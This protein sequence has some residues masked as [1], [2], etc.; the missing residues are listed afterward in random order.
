M[1]SFVT[2]VFVGRKQE[3]SQLEHAL[4]A[5]QDGSGRCVLVSGEAGIGKSRLLAEIRDRAVDR[6]FTALVGRC[7]E[8]DTTF[9]Y[10][11]LVDLLRTCFA[12]RELSDILDTLG[13]Q[14]PAV[15]KLL[16]ELAAHVSAQQPEPTPEPE[17]EKRR[18]FE[19]LA[20]FF[21]RQTEAQ[22]LLLTIEDAHWSDAASLEFL[23]FLARRSAPYPL[24]LL[25]SYR[26]AEGQ[27]GL[28]PL[29]TGLDREPIAQALTLEPLT[30]REVARMLQAI[31]DQ[32]QVPSAE[33]VAAVYHL[34]EGNPFLAEEILTSLIARGDIYLAEGR[35]QRKPLAQ[36]D[37]PDS[38]QRLV[39][40]RL[41]RVSQPARRLLDL[42]A[43][44]G[45][46]F[47]F[48]VLQALTG[49]NEKELLAL[50]KELMAAQLV[51][52]ESAEQ[53]AFRHALTREALYTQLLARERQTLH[54][55]MAQT[56]EQI[57]AGALEAH[58]EALAYHF[59]EATL[60]PKALEYA[61]R[62]GA[63]AQALF[64]PHAAIEQF[65]RA[66][67]AL[68]R[69]AQPPP[70]DLYRQRGQAS[71]TLGQFEQARV[72]Y[73]AALEAA[74]AAGDQRATWQALLD[75]GLLWASRDYERTGDYCRQA[76]E[77]TRSME[78][79]AAIGHS[80][81]RLGN[82]LMNSGRPFEALDYHREA[83]DLF[84][85]LDDRPGL[86]A[87][88]DL[89][90]M[91]SNQCGDWA[92]MVTYWERAIPILRDLNDR[93]TL[94]STLAN[95]VMYTLNLEQAHE[96]M[97]LARDIGW[98]AGEAY[99]LGTL[100][101]ALFML[102]HYDR[103]LTTRKQSFEVAQAIEHP[104]W[105]TSGHVFLGRMYTELLALDEAAAHLREGLALARQIGSS[106]FSWVAAGSL[107]S[108]YIWQGNLDA[109]EKLL[110]DAPETWQP[111]L[112]AIRLAQIELALA[113]QDGVGM[114]QLL[115]DIL[116]IE[117]P[118]ETARGAV[119]LLQAPA[120]TL[121]G[122]ALALQGRRAEAEPVL[123]Q[124]V[125]LYETYGIGHHRLWQLYLALGQVYQAASQAER[126]AE[127]FNAARVHIETLASAIGDEALAENFR[128]AGHFSFDN[129]FRHFGAPFVNKMV[130]LI[131]R[132]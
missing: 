119:L 81:N 47:D 37:I 120:L 10:A 124:V 14:A 116:N 32:P 92:A 131:D 59:F 102:G 50:I 122:R 29:L 6:G 126:A 114:L 61:Q 16:P 15:A 84:E 121:H 78:D 93:Q 127:A 19:A 18:L 73:E 13:K 34:T 89:L 88:L 77:L 125:N 91:T 109:A 28:T 118:P 49:H 17:A 68:R 4:A 72:D 43:V 7:F 123:R 80:L 106:W 128:R 79:P 82:W 101:E 132:T 70:P 107:A 67:E 35:W 54:G 1:G 97:A 3:L 75:L 111:V 42:A 108:V 11:P 115:Q 51:V 94:A 38:V 112:F 85:A 57:Y 86:A 45:R 26:S 87:T 69:L 22:P 21:L 25:L 33:F 52:E 48:A 46:S 20:G 5:V 99:A 56:L 24:L 40:Q 62:A 44:S 104:Q 129:I 130:Y 95:V 76:L 96:A 65:T 12:R 98:R 64:A 71:D 117:V 103:G 100:A 105:I 58:L 55:Q 110:V 41:N 23:L 31:L 27:P 63:K 2:P 90:G 66:L 36:I 30:R 39:E 8:Q 113:R 9:P 83:M 53:F 60:W 74:R